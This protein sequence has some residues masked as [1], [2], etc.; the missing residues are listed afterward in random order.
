MLIASAETLRPS[1]EPLLLRAA[2]L[3]ESH[4]RQ[5]PAVAPAA[6]CRDALNGLRSVSLLCRIWIDGEVPEV[7]QRA[8]DPMQQPLVRSIVAAG[9]RVQELNGSADLLAGGLDPETFPEDAGDEMLANLRMAA[10]RVV[11][12]V[13]V[14]HA[15][16]CLLRRRDPAPRLPPRRAIV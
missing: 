16:L 3:L 11:A 9:R 12:A 8:A 14:L 10:W 2:D 7:L 1:V 4:L 15:F 5:E 6:W 13:A